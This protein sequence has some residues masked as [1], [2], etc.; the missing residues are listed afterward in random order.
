MTALTAG[1]WMAVEVAV[2][3]AMKRP[4]AKANLE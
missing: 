1:F 2:D 3:I 4:F